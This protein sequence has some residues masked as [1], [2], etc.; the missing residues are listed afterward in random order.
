MCEHVFLVK[1]KNTTQAQLYVEHLL[2]TYKLIRYDHF[3]IKADQILVT[4]DP[5]FYEEL[6]K[7]LILNRDTLKNFLDDLEK[8]GYTTIGNLADMPQ[9]Y[10][11]KILHLVAHFLD[12]FFSIDSYFYNLVEASHWMSKALM[13]K[14][15]SDS[16]NFF[17]IKVKAYLEDTVY[18]F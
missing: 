14:I 9:G 18:K 3:E 15:K 11:S 10:L 13:R 1:A 16:K 4:Q 7:A 8:G 2:R 5:S 17:L 6:E 12:G